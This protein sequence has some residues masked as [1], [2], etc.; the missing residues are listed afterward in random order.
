MFLHSEELINRY[1]VKR[2]KE[3][4]HCWVIYCETLLR[5]SLCIIGLTLSNNRFNL[6]TQFF[7]CFSALYFDCFPSYTSGCKASLMLVPI[8]LKFS[9]TDYKKT[10]LF[11]LCPPPPSTLCSPQWQSTC[12]YIV[13]HY[14]KILHVRLGVAN[15]MHP[16]S[17]GGGGGGGTNGKDPKKPCST[18][19][20]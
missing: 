20:W 19:R 11:R 4:I 6:R 1:P 12:H 16:L 5:Q 8:R 15:N 10:D 7:K 13:N 9:V 2:T 3:K 14:V 17:W 18:F